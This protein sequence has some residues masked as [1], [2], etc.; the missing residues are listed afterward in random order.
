M[1]PFGMDGWRTYFSD[2]GF[3]N[4]GACMNPIGGMIRM[5]SFGI[6]WMDEILFA[7]CR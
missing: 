6:A 1:I 3:Q 2:V 7:W 4:S 5:D